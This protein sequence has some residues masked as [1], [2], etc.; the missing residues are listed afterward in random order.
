MTEINKSSHENVD[1]HN[2]AIIRND[3]VRQTFYKAWQPALEL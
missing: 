3:Q 2:N 1:N